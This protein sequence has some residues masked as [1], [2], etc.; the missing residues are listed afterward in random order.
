MLQEQFQSPELG[1]KA[2]SRAGNS[3]RLYQEKFPV[4]VSPEREIL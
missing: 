4:Q 3:S 2:Q 1:I